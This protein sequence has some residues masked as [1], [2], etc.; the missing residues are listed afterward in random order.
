MIRRLRI[1]GLIILLAST[2]LHAQ[3]NC[4]QQLVMATDEFNAGRFYGIP[5]LLKQCLDRGFTK[6]Q[7]QR[8]YILLTQVYLLLDDPI[9]AEESYLKI[10][11]ANPEYETNPDIDPIDVVYLSKRF[12]ASPI[13][14]IYG[15]VGANT[16]LVRVI[17]D[18]NT[19]SGPEQVN[20]SYIL[21]PGFHAFV[22]LDWHAWQN[23]ALSAE[24]GYKLTA[25]RKDQGQK[26]RLDNTEFIDRQAW[27]SL[28][29]SVKYF[30]PVGKFKPYGFVGYSLNLLLSDKGEIRIFNQDEGVDQNII[31]KV[32]ESPTLDMMDQRRTLNHAVF[33]GGGVRYK[34]KLDYLFAEIRYTMG[35]TN[36]VQ[37]SGVFSSQ[38]MQAYG[39]TD[40]YF[41]LD[42]LG[43]SFGFIK[44]L[45]KP[46]KLKNARTKSVLRK[47][48]KEE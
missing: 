47:L 29:I 6:E 26:Y 11:E 12:T 37:P 34:W 14:S 38:A 31:T 1:V 44:P 22:G 20:T 27:L 40:D 32:T 41:R 45:Y 13:F 24:L 23:F 36:V 33:I 7:R 21:R 10:L 19:Y 48:K 39:H 15:R 5:G 18:V 46:R 35:L 28:P 43:I 30:H 8:A 2:A 17:H 4:E 9:G 16:S 3:D 25:Y 42:Q